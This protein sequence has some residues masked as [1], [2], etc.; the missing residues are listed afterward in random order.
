[1]GAKGA[2]SG[3]KERQIRCPFHS[4]VQFLRIHNSGERAAETR[5]GQALTA[6]HPPLLFPEFA[7]L[8]RQGPPLGSYKN[9]SGRSNSIAISHFYTTSSP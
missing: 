7:V 3:S 8:D 1:M 5:S 4:D 9:F 6:N 2:E